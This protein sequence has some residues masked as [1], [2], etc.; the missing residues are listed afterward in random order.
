MQ[1]LE[2][3]SV[4]FSTPRACTHLRRRVQIGDQQRLPPASAMAV[5]SVSTVHP[6]CLILFWARE[7][8]VTRSDQGNDGWPRLMGAEIFSSIPLAELP[9]QC[10]NLLAPLGRIVHLG[11]RTLK[12]R[13]QFNLIISQDGMQ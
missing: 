7:E 5:L 12:A 9:K 6:N 11:C 4:R 1:V 10:R 8:P 13:F 2:Q 3:K